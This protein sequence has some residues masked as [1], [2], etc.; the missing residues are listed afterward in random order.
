[1]LTIL[2]TGLASIL[3]VGGCKKKEQILVDGSSTVYPITEAVAE[4]YRKVEPS[5]NVTVGI[6]GTGGGFKKFCAG[7]TD[8]SDASRPIKQKEIDKCKAAGI[9]YLELE[10]AYDG[11]SIVVQKGNS[12]LKHI[13]VAQLKKIFQ[14]KD[15]AKTWN[16]VD[17]SYPNEKIVVFA[18]GQDSG[19]YDYFIE[20]ILGKKAKMRPDATFS[21][22]DNVLVTGVAGNKYAIG[23]FGLAYYEENADKLDVVSVVNPKTKKAVT[24]SLE[25]VKSGEYAPLSRPLF[26][27]PSSKGIQRPSVRKFL[28][29]Y[30]QHAGTLSKDVGYI[31]LPQEKY[32]AD[33]KRLSEFQ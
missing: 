17:P 8:I 24:P 19:T 14:A 22:D 23:F 31:P 29:F 33:L 27:Y 12:F 32:D 1:M 9:Q 26:I 11:L 13:T 16:E 4:E 21:E 20:A 7:E 15:Y 3:L 18:P 30:I 6:S 28:E 5:V 10:V 25:T 2:A